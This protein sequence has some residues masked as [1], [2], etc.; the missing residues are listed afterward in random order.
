MI[1]DRERIILKIFHDYYVRNLSQSEIAARHF[2]SRQKV[3][4]FLEQGRS[5][6]LVEVRIRFPERIHGA[7]ES[8]LEDK[9]G[10]LEAIVA[11]A[12]PEH[13]FAMARR[14]ISE[15]AADYFLRVVGD[16]MVVS[17]CWSTFVSGMVD[18]I[19]RK[20][21]ATRDRPADLE[22]VQSFG[23]VMSGEQDLAIF[24]A[25][26]RLATALGAKLHLV[27]APGIAASIGAHRALM[28]DPAVA[29][30][31][32][33][34]RK[35]DAA[36]LGIGAVDGES[37][38]VRAAGAFPGLLAKLKKRGVVGDMNGRFFDRH[39]NPVE[40]EIDERLIG[41]TLDELRELPLVVGVS[42]GPGK[43][44]ALRASL[45]GGLVKTVITDVDNARRLLAEG[46]GRP[47]SAA[48]KKRQGG[49]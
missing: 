27:M 6:N 35:S 33:L 2:I 39:G 48:K 23:V 29:G 12:D 31:L 41:L 32:A 34:A 19:V 36:F 30:V 46:A 22:L 21:D 45:E 11:S 38:L 1:V 14:D 25:P 15:F 16:G 43:Y 26:R 20:I 5:E 17:V 10:L 4:R 3:Q 44:E 37:N 9:Y 42:G 7:V 47:R 49:K 18:Q 13:D 40:S 24:D 28:E 8:E